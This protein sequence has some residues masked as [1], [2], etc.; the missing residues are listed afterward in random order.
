[1][2]TATPDPLLTAE[3]VSDWLKKPIGTLYQWRHLGRGPRSIKVGGSVRYRRSDIESWL[4]QNHDPA[5][6]E[7]AS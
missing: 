7:V 3:D 4:E 6:E 5:G 2:A 1:M